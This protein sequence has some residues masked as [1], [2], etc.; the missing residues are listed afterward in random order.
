MF[1]TK[2]RYSAI[3]VWDQHYLNNGGHDEF[4]IFKF[5]TGYKTKTPKFCVV[6]YDIYGKEKSYIITEEEL[7]E[8]FGKEILEKIPEKANR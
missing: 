7:V 3:K 4:I 1:I 5:N 8:S 2:R 6:E